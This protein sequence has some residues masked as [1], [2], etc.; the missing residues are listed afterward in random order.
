MYSIS[1]KLRYNPTSQCYSNTLCLD[2]YPK[3]PL[4]QQIVKKTQI[5]KLSPF[6]VAS[7]C[8][9]KSTCGNCLIVPGTQHPACLEDLP[10]VLEALNNRGYIP[11]TSLTMTLNSGPNS[12]SSLLFYITKSG[13]VT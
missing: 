10:L 12:D 2:R 1:S 4:L 8:N 5:Y 11:N 7:Q 13:P 6:D 3:C 9:P